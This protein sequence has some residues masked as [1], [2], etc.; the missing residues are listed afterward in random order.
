[1]SLV[2][3]NKNVIAQKKLPQHF[4]QQPTQSFSLHSTCFQDLI[5][6]Q[7]I[8][9]ILLAFFLSFFFFFFFLVTFTGFLKSIRMCRYSFKKYDRFCLCISHWVGGGQ[10]E[11]DDG[12]RKKNRRLDFC[13]YP[14]EEKDTRAYIQC[15][16]DYHHHEKSAR[17]TYQLC[18]DMFK[19][20]TLTKDGAS[21]GSPY[22][23]QIK[24]LNLVW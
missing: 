1:M 14:N 13:I 4:H 2:G 19:F 22:P 9:S 6:Q 10:Q 24:S 7:L 3:C 23:C 21:L 11:G 17:K 12:K 18:T 20:G 16:L 5:C 15:S 8:F